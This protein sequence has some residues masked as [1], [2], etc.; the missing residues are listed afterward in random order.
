MTQQ[1]AAGKDRL[2]QT[3]ELF[4]QQK[5]IFPEICGKHRVC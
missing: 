1:N 5:Q 2:V 4:F 3:E